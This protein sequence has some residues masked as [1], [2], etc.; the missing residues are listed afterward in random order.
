[1][2]IEIEFEISDGFEAE[3]K[4]KHWDAKST[5][6]IA[7]ATVYRLSMVFFFHVYPLAR[8]EFLWG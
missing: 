6:I 2:K 3:Y 8:K 7:G 4:K 5:L 1:M